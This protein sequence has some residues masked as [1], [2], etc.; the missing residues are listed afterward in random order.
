[1]SSVCEK[2]GVEHLTRYGLPACKAHTKRGACRAHPVHGAA[3]CSK[4][5]MNSGAKRNAA[6]R[7]AAEKI[8]RT[9]AER[10]EKHYRPDEHPIAALLDQAREAA[11]LTRTLAEMVGEYRD[12]GHDDTLQAALGLY[13]RIGRLSAQ[14]NKM[15][16]DANLDERMVRIHEQE[17]EAVAVAAE[18]AIRELHLPP[19]QYAAFRAVFGRE[20]H[21]YAEGRKPLPA[22][23]ETHNYR[24]PHLDR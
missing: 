3:V 18:T 22:V 16:L 23:P 6:V 4:H 11:A 13:E 12:T 8:A 2:C 17:T 24:P 14:V 19:D 10:K 5:G 1:M 20:L 21:A 15:V 9:M 7:V